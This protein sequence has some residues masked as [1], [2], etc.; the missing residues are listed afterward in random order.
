MYVLLECRPTFELPSYVRSHCAQLRE[1]PATTHEDD[2]ESAIDRG[3]ELMI[4]IITPVGQ[5]AST[6]EYSLR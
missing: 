4:V 1:S 5:A 3:H 2:T 6:Y